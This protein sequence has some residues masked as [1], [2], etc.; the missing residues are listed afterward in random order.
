MVAPEF[1]I[2][3]PPFALNLL[4]GFAS[5]IKDGLTHC[6][7]KDVGRGL[8]FPDDDDDAPGC[9]RGALAYPG[10]V[11]REE[12]LRELDVLLTGGRLTPKDSELIA[13]AYDGADEGKKIKAAQQAILF[14]SAFNNL[15]ETGTNGTRPAKSPAKEHAPHPYKAVVNVFLAG[16]ADTYQILVPRECALHDDYAAVRKGANLKI[17]ELLPITASTQKCANFGVNK[18]MPNLHKMYNDKEAAFISNVGFL[19]EPTTRS[20]LKGGSTKKCPNQFSH[21][22]AQAMAQSCQC[23][24]QGGTAGLMADE[25]SKK[26][27]AVE[28]FS[29]SGTSTWSAGKDT[30]TEILSQNDGVVRFKTYDMWQDTIGNMTSQKYGNVYSDN[31][32]QAF[33]GALDQS[34]NLGKLLEGLQDATLDAYKRDTPLEKQL[35]QVARVI[36]A[37]EARKAERDFFFVQLGGWDMHTGLQTN[38][39]GKLKQVDDALAGFVAQMKAL[40]V[41][42]SVTVVTESDFGRTLS[43]NGAGTD[44]GW[45]GNH[46]ILGGDVNGGVVYN[47]FLETY[48]LNSE[49]DAGRGRVI[50]KFP[51]ESMMVPIAEWVGVDS[52]EVLFPNLA[53][54]NRSEHI[55][56]TKSLFKSKSQAIAGTAQRLNAW[57]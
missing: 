20:Q 28:S 9:A 54:F 41:F 2:F 31:Y 14:T 23:G 12:T 25:L 48:Q 18:N 26:D 37:R 24:G 36:A 7:D 15:G 56:S 57:R 33:Q 49:Y 52:P 5:L 21:S 44:H 50:P 10:G 3:T 45:G 53:N 46:I 11:N 40:K 16:G 6:I 32:A 27:M 38:L 30:H 4:N 42:D 17:G 51:W 47:E 22:H 34:E 1:Q 13:E 35:Y 29:V 43:Y 39:P 8:G 19:V 55:I